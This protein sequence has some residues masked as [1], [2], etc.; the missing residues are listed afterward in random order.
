MDE[1]AVPGKISLSNPKEEGMKKAALVI[2]LCMLLAVA[3]GATGPMDDKEFRTGLKHY[4]SRNYKAAVIH[5]REYAGKHPDP[6]VYYFIGYSLYELGSF[7]ES[8]EYFREAFF[9]DPEFSLEKAGFIKKES[10]GTATK[11]PVAAE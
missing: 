9:I 11:A 8:N 2:A 4:N 6:V 10:V 5:F 3:A 1:V 7:S